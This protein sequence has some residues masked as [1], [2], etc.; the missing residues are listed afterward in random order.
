[1]RVKP[2]IRPKQEV[3]AA[4]TAY[5]QRH[6]SSYARRIKDAG[7]FAFPPFESATIGSAYRIQFNARL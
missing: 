7:A 6:M 1:M 2:L 3:P 5:T 4:K